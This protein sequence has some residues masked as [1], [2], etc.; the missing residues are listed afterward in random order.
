MLG[1]FYQQ[2]LMLYRELTSSTTRSQPQ[3]IRNKSASVSELL[4]LLTQKIFSSSEQIL[5][6]FRAVPPLLIRPTTS[7]PRELFTYLNSS[8]GNNSPSMR[9]LWCL[10]LFKPSPHFV[11]GISHKTKIFHYQT[12]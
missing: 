11:Y 10:S 4:K 1:P 12:V 8:S 5:L 2:P 6:K 9:P 3:G 7:S